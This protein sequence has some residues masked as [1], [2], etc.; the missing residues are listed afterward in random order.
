MSFGTEDRC[1]EVETGFHGVVEVNG[2]V[3]VFKPTL[4]SSIA[5]QK[6][7]KGSGLTIETRTKARIVEVACNIQCRDTAKSAI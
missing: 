5:N 2:L 7:D 4:Y 6:P 1:L 3:W